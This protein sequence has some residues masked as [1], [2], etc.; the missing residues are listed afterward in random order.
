M[1]QLRFIPWLV[2]G[3][4]CWAPFG[5]SR[6]QDLP[7]V[8]SV[9][10]TLASPA[11]KGRGYVG[12]G[13]SLAAAYLA[14][15]FQRI[16]ISAFGDSYYQ[17]FNLKVNTHPGDLRLQI[18]GVT[19]EPG[20]DYLLEAGSPGRSGTFKTVHI[21]R[22]DLT[23]GESWVSKVRQVNNKVLMITED[24]V[25]GLDKVQTA[26]VDG[27]M[28]V[29]KYYEQVASAGVVVFSSE[30]LTH[31]PSP[32]VYPRPVFVVNR[33]INTDTIRQ[34][35]FTIESEFKPNYK[36]RNLVGYLPGTEVPDTILMLTA[37]YDHLG[38]MGR[39]VYFPGAND[40]ASGVAM[41]LDM[42]RYFVQNRP[43]Y[44]VLFIAFAG[45]E[46]GLAGSRYYSQNALFTLNRVKFLINLDLEGTGDEGITVV[47]ATVHQ[48]EYKRL[49]A[50][51]MREGYLSQ[52]KPRGEA[53][54]SDHC[55]FHQQGVPCFYMYTLGGSQAYHDI[56]DVPGNLS[57]V[58]Y[59]DYFKLLTAFLEE[60]R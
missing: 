6:A 48:D 17:P 15:E 57:L 47:N 41:M 49:F 10:N 1:I 11:M 36:T 23:M 34:I 56:D 52:I 14:G 53:C 7:Y 20:R 4:L 44:S 59:E 50:I 22:S 24:A 38:M 43:R 9:I 42:A 29:L 54:N 16:G 37:H 39:K 28:K 26:K 5:E 30:K 46:I 27:I 33:P 55:F 8:K 58:D 19:L 60:M 13:D 35:S 40:N 32:T 21:A 12:K 2:L 31:S 45:E 3:L 25:A 51:N 18:N